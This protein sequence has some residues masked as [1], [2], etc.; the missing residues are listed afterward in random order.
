MLFNVQS[1]NNNLYKNRNERHRGAPGMAD[2]DGLIQL[3]YSYYTTAYFVGY[4][5]AFSEGR[6]W[7]V[8]VG[9]N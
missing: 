7:G 2:S 1:A 8:R 9:K 5:A 3:K 6:G 4:R